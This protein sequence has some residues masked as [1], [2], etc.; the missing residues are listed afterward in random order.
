M[1]EVKLT[2][3][4]HYGDHVIPLTFPDAWEI[5]EIGMACKDASPMVDEEIRSALT[6]SVGSPNIIDQAKG[7][8]GRVVITCDDLS[9][10]TP[11]GRVFPFIF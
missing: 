3:N 7:K 5:E 1:P 2:V 6:A 8:R 9:R 4:E 10:P 11:A